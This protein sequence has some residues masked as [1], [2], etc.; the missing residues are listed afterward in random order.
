MMY[1]LSCGFVDDARK[2]L[3][4]L[5]KIILARMKRAGIV[6]GCWLPRMQLL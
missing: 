2:V 4:S 1:V 3:W 6:A 5:N